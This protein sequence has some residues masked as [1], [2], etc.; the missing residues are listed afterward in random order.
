M[1]CRLER[2]FLH[3]AGVTYA[4]GLTVGRRRSSTHVLAGQDI[5]LEIYRNGV[6]AVHAA[7]LSQTGGWALVTCV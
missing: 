2:H 5:T 3:L 4:V 1:R 7:F 6:T